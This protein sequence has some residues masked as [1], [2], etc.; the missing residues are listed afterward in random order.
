ML[1]LVR[2]PPMNT[3]SSALNEPPG[4]RPIAWAWRS[5]SVRTDANSV[6][7]TARSPVNVPDADWVANVLARSISR[8]M[9]LRPPSIVCR[10]LSPSAAFRTPCRNTETSDRNRLAMANPAASSAEELI[11]YPDVNLT[12]VRSCRSLVTPSFS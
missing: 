11:R 9:L 6:F 8:E 1:L 2:P 3:D 10:V 4:S 7:S 5:I 12:I